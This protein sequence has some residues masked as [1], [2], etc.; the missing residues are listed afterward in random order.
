MKLREI[1]LETT[2]DTLMKDNLFKEL[3][4]IYGDRHVR[5]IGWL[6]GYKI[7][8]IDNVN[9][10]LLAFPGQIRLRETNAKNIKVISYPMKQLAYRE[11]NEIL[12]NKVE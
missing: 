10:K 7:V 3:K 5:F 1:I 6:D 8:S 9:Y 12:G 4:N 2:V 11:Y